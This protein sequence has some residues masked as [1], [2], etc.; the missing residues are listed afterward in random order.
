[1]LP[2]VTRNT[3][4]FHSTLPQHEHRNNIREIIKHIELEGKSANKGVLVIENISPNL[5]QILIDTWSI[6]PGFF[7][8]H[9]SNPPTHSLWERKP[10]Q[11]AS[12]EDV[13]IDHDKPWQQLRGIYEYH[14]LNICAGRLAEKSTNHHPR[15]IFRDGPW[16]INGTTVI[17]YVRVSPYLCVSVPMRRS[18]GSDH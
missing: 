9:E 12:T 4:F 11:P 18:N 13:D 14:G 7:N 8:D 15:S 10:W 17:S 1:M 2:P 3:T 5:R 16:P 6:D